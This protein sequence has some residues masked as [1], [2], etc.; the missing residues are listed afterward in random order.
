MNRWL[1]WTR[2]L[3]ARHARREH[4]WSGASLVLA[5][6]ARPGFRVLVRGARRTSVSLSV[7]QSLALHVTAA[8]PAAASPA[9]L[10][11][12]RPTATTATRVV[13]QA[14]PDRARA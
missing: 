11:L 10:T 14:P 13:V 7:R 2:R 3:R 1:T 9:S 12:V 8:H 5:R 6:T 4:R